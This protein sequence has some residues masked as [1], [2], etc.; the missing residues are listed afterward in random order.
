MKR[1]FFFAGLFITAF[2][3]ANEPLSK[4]QWMIS[5]E[6]IEKAEKGDPLAQYQVGYYLTSVRDGPIKNQEDGI[7]WLIKSA[8]NGNEKAQFE[9]G[10]IYY[11]G[12][13][14]T[15]NE[16]EGMQWYL[17]A[18]EQENTDAIN[19]IKNIFNN[20]QGEEKF[21]SSAYQKASAFITKQAQENN[22]ELCFAESIK[23]FN[24]NGVEKNEEKGLELMRKSSD[25]GYSVASLALAQILLHGT[26]NIKKDEKTAVKLLLKV[27]D[28][29]NDSTAQTAEKIL[30]APTAQ[31]ILGDCYFEGLGVDLDVKEAVKW[32]H[33]AAA[34]GDTSSSLGDCYF[35]GWGVLKDEGEAFKWYL[36]SAE[37][38]PWGQYMLSKCYK[39]GTGVE[40]N[41][42][43]YRKW[44]NKASER[45]KEFVEW[46]S[47]KTEQTDRQGALWLGRIYMHGIGV[48][49]DENEAKKWFSKSAKNGNRRAQ[50]ELEDLQ[51]EESSK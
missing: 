48:Q 13:N 6:I 23:Y 1:V 40:K 3:F 37:Y 44:F 26:G 46:N 15:T 42:A 47:K 34:S 9:L 39:E 19:E 35:N 17:R 16:I 14:V 8:E 22:P 27:A 29:P 51:K 49:K 30:T 2:V 10:G 31:R 7:K 32:Y 38:D 41:D 25:L 11:Y 43:E 21:K 24:G 20:G 4:E 28:E 33:K 12:E 36:K 45:A 50:K 18:A 5:K